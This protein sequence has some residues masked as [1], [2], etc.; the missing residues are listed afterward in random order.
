ML[1]DFLIDYAW[2][3]IAILLIVF[4]ITKFIII[5]LFKL[6][7]K[8]LNTY[9]SSLRIANQY[10]I[11]T[12]NGNN[13]KRYYRISNKVN[14]LFYIVNAGVVLTYIFLKYGV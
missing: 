4:T 6:S 2:G 7:K 3:V 13:L 9:L 11:A 14:A 5:R 8:Y 12:S 1:K 10:V